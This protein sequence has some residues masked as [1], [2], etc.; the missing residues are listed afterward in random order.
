M[1]EEKQP[2]SDKEVEL[3][4]V[5]IRVLNTLERALS[6]Y[7]QLTQWTIL[8]DQMENTVEIRIKAAKK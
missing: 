7:Q 3:E 6:R 8:Y 5:F 2:T 1:G 4:E